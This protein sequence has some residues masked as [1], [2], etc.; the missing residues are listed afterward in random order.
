MHFLSFLYFLCARKMKNEASSHTNTHTEHITNIFTK[1]HTNSPL[2]CAMCISKNETFWSLFVHCALRSRKK[3]KKLKEIE[4]KKRTKKD[5]ICSKKANI[6][7]YV[8]HIN[9][10][11][12]LVRVTLKGEKMSLLFPW[13]D[14]ADLEAK[15]NTT[16]SC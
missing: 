4:K 9:K 15:R 16:K 13:D 14:L 5:S 1:T 7:K 12:A 2:F 6:K 8:I 3:E 11:R 10:K